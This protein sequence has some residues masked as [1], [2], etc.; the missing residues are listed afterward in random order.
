MEAIVQSIYGNQIYNSSILDLPYYYQKNTTINE[1]L[2]INN[3]AIDYNNTPY[4]PLLKYLAIGNGGHKV[5]EGNNGLGEPEPIQHLSTDANLYN[6]LPFVIVQQNQDLSTA[7]QANYALKTSRVINGISYFLYYLRKIQTTDIALVTTEN[8]VSNGE[9]VSKSFT[10]TIANLYPTPPLLNN[11]DP[12]TLVP[13]TIKAAINVNFSLTST[14]ISYFMEVINIVPEARSIGII[15][16]VALCT[17]VWDN[18]L[19]DVIGVQ[20][21]IFINTFF[22]L[23]FNMSSLN[24]QFSLGSTKPLY[25]LTA[26]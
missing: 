18:T 17:G 16:E 14:E 15:S 4:T 1:A 25:N 21:A 10:P 23:A 12:Y 26:T 20:P 8:N 11:N 7:E 6:I 13:S 19:G 3:S 22:P 24:Y 9:I 2:S 5:V